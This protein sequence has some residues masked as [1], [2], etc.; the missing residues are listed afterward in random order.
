MKNARDIFIQILTV[1]GSN[2]RKE[3]EVDDF[4]TWVEVQVM[5]ELFASLP[6]DKQEQAIDQFMTLPPHKKERVF[7]P[8]FSVEFMKERV[9]KATKAAILQQIVE[10]HRQ[11]LSPSQH[12][13]ILALLE[14]LTY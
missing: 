11:R 3:R 8:Y 12:E 6:V 10:P 2:Q 7:Y 4:C 13:R 1:I 5:T 9:Q 14:K